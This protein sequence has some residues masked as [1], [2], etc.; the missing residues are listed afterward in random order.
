MRDVKGAD[1]ILSRGR[2]ARGTKG[3]RVHH[4]HSPCHPHS[5]SH[6]QVNMAAT[7]I[8]GIMPLSIPQRQDLN[9]SWLVQLE[10]LNYVNNKLW[11]PER[12]PEKPA[13]ST[14]KGDVSSIPA[15]DIGCNKLLCHPA[16]CRRPIME[17]ENL[18]SKHNSAPL[19][20]LGGP[21]PS[22]A[23]HQAKR[24]PQEPHGEPCHP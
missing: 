23:R 4:P 15:A 19:A 16:V 3:P 18:Q 24:V 10:P 2:L 9:D 22:A 7:H 13:L 21:D 11:S 12:S 17:M 1:V 5:T 14:W 8:S 20:S 6:P